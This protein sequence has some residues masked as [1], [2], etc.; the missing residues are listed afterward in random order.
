[1]ETPVLAQIMVST[2]TH[3][4]C[5]TAEITPRGIPTNK[6]TNKCRKTEFNR[7]RKAFEKQAGNRQVIANGIAKITT[8]HL[9]QVNPKLY[10]DGFIQPFFLN[11][12]VTYFISGLFPQNGPARIAGD[13]TRHCKCDQQNAK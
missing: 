10:V 1:M 4:L 2:S 11:K 12:S 9:S 13:Q 6:L 8:K 3:E 5:L 7:G